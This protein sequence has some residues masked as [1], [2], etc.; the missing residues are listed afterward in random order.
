MPQ[1]ICCRKK[2]SR[3]SAAVAERSMVPYELALHI[4]RV[5]HPGEERVA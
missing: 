3:S 1:A 5:F 4:G 2:E